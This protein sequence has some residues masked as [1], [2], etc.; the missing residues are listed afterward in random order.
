MFMGGIKEFQGQFRDW[1]PSQWQDSRLYGF[2]PAVCCSNKLCGKMLTR[3]QAVLSERSAFPGY[4][5][6]DECLPQL[7]KSNMTRICCRPGR[8]YHLFECWNFIYES[9]GK[10]IPRQCPEHD[11]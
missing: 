5:W 7:E 9:Q 2:E 1:W 11:E 4:R 6:C 3:F 8:L 10:G